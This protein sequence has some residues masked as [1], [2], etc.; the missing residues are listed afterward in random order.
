MPRPPSARGRYT[1]AARSICIA[2]GSDRWLVWI[3]RG[4]CV[5]EL[6]CGGSTRPRA[7]SP[8]Q[9]SRG[10]VSARCKSRTIFATS[11]RLH[12]GFRRRGIS[13]F[14]RHRIAKMRTRHNANEPKRANER[15]HEIETI[16][17]ARVCTLTSRPAFVLAGQQQRCQRNPQ[18][19]SSLALRTHSP[20][21]NSSHAAYQSG[22]VSRQNRA[23][24]R[25]QPL[26]IRRLSAPCCRSLPVA[27][28]API[29]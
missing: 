8:V 2:L 25:R 4:T 13:R 10:N 1:F 15:R 19:V 3:A 9:T 22:F 16:Q 26:P 14:A 28:T 21:S 11:A 20:E 24:H 23:V 12:S 18:T 29:A 27:A 5:E 6:W 17:R 7:R